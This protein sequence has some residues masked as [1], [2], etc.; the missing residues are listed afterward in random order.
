M[1]LR[2]LVTFDIPD[3]ATRKELGELL[4]N[5]GLRVQRSVFEIRLKS[6]SERDAL[7][8]AVGK[9]IDPGADSVRIYPQC[10]QCA[11]KAKELGDFPDPFRIGGVYYF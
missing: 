5:Y 3:D 4:E 1:I 10:E 9:L 8:A 11:T 7:F 2:Y 6:P